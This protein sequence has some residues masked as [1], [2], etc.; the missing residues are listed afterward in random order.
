[1]KPMLRHTRTIKQQHQQR[2]MML[3]SMVVGLL[4]YVS[5]FVVM[6]SRIGS[7][8]KMNSAMWN[9]NNLHMASKGG[10]DNNVATHREKNLH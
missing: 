5:S 3:S 10:I 2:L 4:L 6:F 9:A 7:T 8:D 1:M